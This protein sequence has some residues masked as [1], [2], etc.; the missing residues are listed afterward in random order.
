MMPFLDVEQ[1]RN[2]E[3][4]FEDLIIGMQLGLVGSRV[5]IRD[6]WVPQV[7]RGSG[8]TVEA[9]KCFEDDAE[10]RIWIPDDGQ[11]KYLSR[12]V[13]AF[14]R[15]IGMRA[16]A[17]MRLLDGLLC[18]FS[19]PIENHFK[20]FS[21]YFTSLADTVRNRLAQSEFGRLLSEQAAICASV[22]REPMAAQARIE[23]REPGRYDYTAIVGASEGMRRVFQKLDRIIESD[24]TVLIQGE[25]GTGKELIARAIHF[26]GPRKS[27]PFVTENCAALP[28]SLLESELFGHVPGAFTGARR[29]KKGLFEQADGGTL[30]L[31]EI[32]D[33][34]PEMQKKVL[35]VLQEGEFRPV[36][37]E[38]KIKVDVRLIAASHQ[39][40]DEMVAAGA[41]RED[42]YYRVHVLTVDLPPLRERREDIPLLAEALL[43]RAAREAGRAVPQLPREVL[44]ALVAYDW[45]GNVRELENEMRRLVV[46]AAD[47]VRLEHLSSAVLERRVLRA[48]STAGSAQLSEAGAEDQEAKPKDDTS[49]AQTGESS[50]W[51]Q[52]ALDDGNP[53]NV[54]EMIMERLPQSLEQDDLVDKLRTAIEFVKR[55]VRKFNP[56][57]NTHPWARAV[58]LAIVNE[59]VQRRN[60]TSQDAAQALVLAATRAGWP[61]TWELEGHRYSSTSKSRKRPEQRAPRETD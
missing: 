7:G 14:D 11:Y 23:R 13:W 37:S 30:F 53:R 22:A 35:R 59:L 58:A 43:A 25:S 61:V 1:F 9:F 19:S 56:P 17:Y 26:N 48:P 55:R 44:A 41:F 5:A 31:D 8:C 38:E 15:L 27:K 4:D 49:G 24:I 16:V 10:L 34:S 28:D 47:E 36:G 21:R 57:S 40:L 18:V 39:R 52:E 60:M 33:M 32:G 2:Q 3:A 42:L 6:W 50:G 54:A 20:T 45:P 46:L 51:S 12:D 29:G